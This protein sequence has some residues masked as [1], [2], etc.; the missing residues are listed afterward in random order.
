MSQGYYFPKDCFCYRPV[1]QNRAKPISS[2]HLI[3]MTS[4]PRPPC[5]EP[6]GPE[7]TPARPP[8][9]WARGWP[10]LK[11]R[12]Y[13]TY[14]GFYV[15]RVMTCIIQL[16]RLCLLNGTILGVT[17]VSPSPHS[18]PP[19]RQISTAAPGGYMC[20]Y[21]CVYIYIYICSILICIYI[22]IYIIIY[23][24]IYVSKAARRD[25]GPPGLHRGIGQSRLRQ[26]WLKKARFSF[27]DIGRASVCL[28]IQRF[29]SQ[30]CPSKYHPMPPYEVCECP[31]VAAQ[32][33]AVRLP[34]RHPIISYPTI[35]YYMIAEYIYIY[36]YI[37]T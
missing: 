14:G 36:I 30:Y 11:A 24:Y 6:L 34:F 7:T 23:I 31:H 25:A 9:A 18:R 15:V 4:R 1:S 33:A 2:P 37:Y 26:H 10:P 28:K 27:T 17:F 5:L 22:Y 8:V 12:R 32:L 13:I 16:V 20:M 21:V 29:L 19:Q 35:S 3:T